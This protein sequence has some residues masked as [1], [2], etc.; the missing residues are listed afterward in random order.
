MK[1]F[2]VTFFMIALFIIG[3]PA[4]GSKNDKIDLSSEKYIGKGERVKTITSIDEMKKA[5]DN[6]IWTH[7]KENYLWHKLQFKGNKVEQYTAI[8]SNSKKWEYLGSSPYTLKKG[9]FPDGIE[10]IAAEFTM[11]DGSV[12][13]EFVLTNCHLYVSGIDIGVFDNVDIEW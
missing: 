10:Y 6:T 11:I 5:I 7:S 9:S 12:L 1:N 8:L 13:A 4:S 3:F 2:Y